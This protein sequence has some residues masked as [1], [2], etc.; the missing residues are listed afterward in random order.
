[1]RGLKPLVQRDMAG[2]ENG[3]DRDRE[4]ALTG[5]AAV[6]ARATATDG[7]DT[8]KAATTRAMHAIRPDYILKPLARRVL[9][10]KVWLRKNAHGDATNPLW[11]QHKRPVVFVKY[12]ITGIDKSTQQETPAGEQQAERGH[13]RWDDS[14]N[15][16]SA[17]EAMTEPT[18]TA[19]HV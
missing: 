19:N 3:A 10:V 17:M 14:R 4:L 8:V 15:R 1:V 6:Q 12:I 2:L 18:R 13:G 16:P 7:R 9:A 5:A 11:S